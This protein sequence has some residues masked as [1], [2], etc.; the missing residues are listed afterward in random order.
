MTGVMGRRELS[1]GVLLALLGLG[2]TLVV[3]R[4]QLADTNPYVPVMVI[5]G[6]GSI[7]LSF[8]GLVALYLTAGNRGGRSRL[9]AT[10]KRP[11]KPDMT[12]RDLVLYVGAGSCWGAAIAKTNATKAANLGQIEAQIV[13][14]ISTGRVAVWGR[15]K[16]G[17][18][19]VQIDHLALAGAQ[20]QMAHDRVFLPARAVNIYEVRVSRTEAE[21][22]WPPRGQTQASPL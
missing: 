8:V 1:A 9:R 22:A 11:F 2:G 10:V 3:T 14:M 17:G 20:I 13:E 15:E 16:P 4:T 19:E 5:A 12:M 7:A 6:W 21:H 18:S